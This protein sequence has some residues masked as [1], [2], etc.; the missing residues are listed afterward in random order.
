MSLS[1]A[2]TGR[3]AATY[4][5]SVDAAGL[6]DVLREPYAEYVRQAKEDDALTGSTDDLGRAGYPPLEQL[7]AAP[8]LLTDVLEFFIHPEEVLGPMLLAPP[9]DVAGTWA[10]DTVDSARCEDGTVV[11]EGCCYLF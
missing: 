11:I 8:A 1:S 10:V 7:L 2:R 9:A 4:A 6:L 3:R 5:L